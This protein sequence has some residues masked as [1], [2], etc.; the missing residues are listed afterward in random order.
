MG[1]VEVERETVGDV[2]RTEFALFRRRRKHP[3]TG[4]PVNAIGAFT[5]PRDV[6][7]CPNER[8][9]ARQV[10]PSLH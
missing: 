9:A 3:L 6:I 7:R 4:A 5:S 8:C 1:W 2:T 10:V